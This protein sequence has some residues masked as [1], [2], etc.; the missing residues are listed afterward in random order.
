MNSFLSI[1]SVSASFVFFIIIQGQINFNVQLILGIFFPFK[2]IFGLILANYFSFKTMFLNGRQFF[3]NFQV[4]RQLLFKLLLTK[5]SSFSVQPSVTKVR[6][7]NKVCQLLSKHFRKS[8]QFQ[9]AVQFSIPQP[10][11]ARTDFGY[12]RKSYACTIAI[13]ESSDVNSNYTSVT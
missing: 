5:Y 7:R 10:R 4:Q 9:K 1:C 3:Q 11:E 13:L 2:K 6:K 8:W 12:Q